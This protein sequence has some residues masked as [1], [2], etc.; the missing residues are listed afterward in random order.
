MAEGTE[1][2]TLRNPQIQLPTLYRGVRD[3]KWAA[4]PGGERGQKTPGVP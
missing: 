4:P 2:K 1:E 3:Q